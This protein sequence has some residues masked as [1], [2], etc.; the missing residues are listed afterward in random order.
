MSV[1][2]P[3]LEGLA[4]VLSKQ[5]II[6]TFKS[7]DLWQ[8]PEHVEAVYEQHVRSYIPLAREASTDEGMDAAAFERRLARLVKDAKAPLGYI[9]AEYGH[10]KTSTGLFL[11]QQAREENILAVPPF[12][13]DT[14]ADIIVAVAG[15][16]RFAIERVR[17][18]MGEQVLPIYARCR[19]ENLEA[20]AR[21]EAQ[22]T[23]RPYELV[24]ND[25]RRL[26]QQGRLRIS[27]SGLDY[28]NYLS[29]IAAL[30]K[31]AGYDGLLV[32]ADELQQYV[33]HQD[34]ST[35]REPIADLFDLVNTMYTRSGRLA[36]GLVFLL[37]L[38][39]LGFINQQRGDL[40]ARMKNSRLAL[41][42]AQV[43]GSDFGLQ[44]WRSLSREFGFSNIAS[45]VITD[46]ALRSL[47]EIGGRTDLAQGPRTVVDVLKLACQ[48]YNEGASAPYGLLDLVR[49]FEA[50]DVAFDGISKLQG[51][52]KQA[53][54]HDL[55]R[56]KPAAERA[57]RLMAAFPTTGLSEEIQEREG[58]RDVIDDLQRLG[59][60]DLIALRG[61]GLDSQGRV[62]RAGATLMALRPAE[63]QLSWLKSTI[64][65][66]RQSYYLGSEQ[67]QRLALR[68][69]VALLKDRLFP[70]PQ[71]KVETETAGGVLS[72][73][74]GVL[75]RG[76]FPSAARQFPSRLVY[77]RILG[78][79][80]Q[81]R[82]NLPTHDLLIDFALTLP[83]HLASAS[84]QRQEPGRVQWFAPNHVRVDLNLLHRDMD[85]NYLDLNPGFEDIVAP[86]QVNPLLTLSLFAALADHLA[87]ERVPGAEVG[88]V[89]DL[90][91]PALITAAMRDLFH[92]ELGKTASPAVDAADARFVDALVR[93]LC[94]RTYGDRYVTLMTT[95]TWQAQ[96]RQYCTALRQIDHP[97]IRAGQEPQI[98]SKREIAGLF[99]RSSPALDSFIQSLPALFTVQ[100]GF[101]GEAEGAIK[102]TLH[103]LEKR[104]LDRLRETGGK[105]FMLHP[106]TRQA[107]E[108]PVLTIPDLFSALAPDGYRE[109]EMDVALE[110]LEAR[111]LLQRDTAHGR[112]LALEPEVPDT[113]ETRQAVSQLLDRCQTLRTVLGDPVL[114]PIERS[115][116]PYQTAFSQASTR[117]T[118]GQL[119]TCRRQVQRAQ[120]D[121]EQA[122]AERR[123][124]LAAEAGRVDGGTPDWERVLTPLGQAATGGLFVD[125]LNRARV[126]LHRQVVSLRG[127]AEEVLRSLAQVRIALD[128]AS[129]DDQGLCDA[130]GSVARGRSALDQIRQ[131]WDSLQKRVGDY[132]DAQ[133][134][135]QEATTLLN[136]KLLP[137][138]EAVSEQSQSLDRWSQDI[139][140][141]LSAHRLAALDDVEAWR[142]R[143]HGIS[144]Q[145]A[146]FEQ[147]VREEFLGRQQQLRDL[148]TAKFHIPPS[149][150]PP[151]L[152]FNLADPEG[153]YRLLEQQF[154]DE[155]DRLRRQ[156]HARL[157]EIRRSAK[158]QRDPDK[159]TSLP[160]EQRQMV[161]KDMAD[162]EQT[163]E[164]IGREVDSRFALL[165]ASGASDRAGD[166]GAVGELADG[167]VTVVL[168]VSDL[169]KRVQSVR[170]L[171]QQTALTPA[172]TAAYD[173][174][175][176]LSARGDVDFA[177]FASR[178]RLA[179]EQ[180][181]AWDAV[182]SLGGKARVRVLIQV[183][184]Q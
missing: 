142:G 78:P 8:A 143:L 139:R 122:I 92:S 30:A 146:S 154:R 37:P 124:Q 103:P 23:N 18:G 118:P 67:V 110:L 116:R 109:E 29:E 133:R 176:E 129:L 74:R 84:F 79:G 167:L 45:R 2:I 76:S 66:F 89:R 34:V 26:E 56:G 62:V 145:A 77:C 31:Q 119:I 15:W 168:P 24:L 52:V 138:G 81:E 121:L 75:F 106:R 69:F 65:E 83:L 114:T 152:T 82:R 126:D 137:F 71:W 7:Q 70:A 28:V 38:K 11:W 165:T 99:G 141:A 95:S 164:T 49:A 61:G 160:Q 127:K 153:S 17:P 91:L 140:G 14:L 171:L 104:I 111:Q 72:A 48:R 179:S 136:E 32:I 36:C 184:R 20:L 47:G 115:L 108:V 87:A 162:V 134:L 1:A 9:T 5:P 40:V 33:E 182:K 19:R 55:V 90:F 174:L 155:I 132:R 85:A 156:T 123:R 10:G 173:I 117:L 125:Q 63:S 44:L 59:G 150:L 131:Q 41:D 54:A 135:L 39:E 12:S 13:L 170:K 25:L 161:Q 148:L 113:E 3:A 163:V 16:A 43:Y 130:A 46:E 181:D 149:A 42:L 73:N 97:L 22:E 27:L 51:A 105:Q 21:T 180:S 157:E 175:N 102:L 120:Q 86:Y 172:E 57:V 80:E 93:L 4:A 159:L 64:R 96:L 53:L 6:P 144:Q 68:G 58:V 166:F 177:D 128:A 107:I 101:R 94:E 60:G 98:G 50:N 151:L 169:M 147:R 158:D 35:A 183:L 100:T 88:N 112:V 178:W